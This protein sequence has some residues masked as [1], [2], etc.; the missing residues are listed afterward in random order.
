MGIKRCRILRRL[1]KYKLTLV[2]KCTSL[3]GQFLMWVCEVNTDLNPE[4][5][6][7]FP[8]AEIDL[9]LCHEEVIIVVAAALIDVVVKSC[10]HDS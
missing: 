8:V 5:P 6:D 9:L 7:L 4:C 1:K 2:T 3:P 10:G